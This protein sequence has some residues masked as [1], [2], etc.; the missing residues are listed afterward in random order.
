MENIFEFANFYLAFL[1]A[2]AILHQSH[3]WLTRGKNF[4]GNH[5]LLDRIYRTAADNSDLAA[6]KF[7]GVLG[8]EVLDLS[9]HNAYI[10]SILKSFEGEDPIQISLA[11]EEKFQALSEKLY[12]LLE[13]SGKLTLGMDDMIMSIASKSE[14]SSYLLGQ[15]EKMTGKKEAKAMARKVVLSRIAKSLRK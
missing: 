2:L 15:V 8:D 6:E 5:L 14:E 10:H 1:R 7:V 13:K 12:D 11:A 9:L 3:H 4:Y